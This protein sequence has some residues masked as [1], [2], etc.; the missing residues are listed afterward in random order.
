L[1]VERIISLVIR[2][3]LFQQVGLSLVLLKV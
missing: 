1:E 2:V 3:S